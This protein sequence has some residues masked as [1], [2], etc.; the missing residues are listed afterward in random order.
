M[1]FT[2]HFTW[3]MLQ[4]PAFVDF[5]GSTS[6]GT[7]RCFVAALGDV[8]IATGAYFVTA[9][10]FHR[11]AWAVRPG[12]MLPALTWIAVGVIAM[13]AIERR[14]LAGGR[15]AYEPE[16]PVVFGTGL[17][18]LLQWLIVPALTLAVVQQ[19]V[20]RSHFRVRGR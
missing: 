3:E 14:A 9:L 10:T 8:V 5:A 13:V 6:Q 15:W 12:W 4:A 19:L 20:W 2:L 11:S 18:P 1:T 7:L 17:L 16:M